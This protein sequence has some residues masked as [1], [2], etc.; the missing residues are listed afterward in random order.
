MARLIEICQL[1]SAQYVPEG[2]ESIV[3]S[4][5]GDL[6]QA[7]NILQSTVVGFGLVTADNVF[8][9]FDQPHVAVIQEIIE[10]CSAAHVEKGIVLL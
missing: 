5:D 10:A 4:C 6:R 8:R 1:E 7:V 2:I 3:F 9:V